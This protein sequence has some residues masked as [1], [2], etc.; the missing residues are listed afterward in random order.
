VG[1]LWLLVKPNVV[2]FGHT[3]RLFDV[4]GAVAIVGL[5]AIFTATAIAHTRALYR[6]EPRIK[7]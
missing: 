5:L 3:F 7:P 6:A 1:A 2:L 4:G